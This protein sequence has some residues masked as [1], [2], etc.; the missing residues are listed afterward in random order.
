M[1][2]HRPRG[3]VRHVATTMSPMAAVAGKAA[4]Q[5]QAGMRVERLKAAAADRWRQRRAPTRPR[6][7]ALSLAPGAKFAW[8]QAAA[9]PLPQPG[10]A[11]VH[12]IAAATCDIDRALGLGAAPFPL[13][14]HF[15]HECVAEVVE[16]GDGVS[17]LRPGQRVI[18]PFQI[19][20]GRCPACEQGRTG[21][22]ESLPPISMY[23]FGL[24]GGHWGGTVS[25][26]LAVPF[27]EAM[28]VPVPDGVETAAVA[29]AA[30]NLADAHGRLAHHLP[31]LVEQGRGEVLI[32][33]SLSP[34]TDFSASVPLYVGQVALALGATRVRFADS[35]PFL[36][37][38]AERL[39]IEAL[40]SQ[41]LDSRELSPLT[42][43]ASASP[44]GLHVAIAMT[45][46]DGLVNSIGSL[47]T[48]AK[49]PTGLMFARNV[50]VHVGRSHAR[51]EIPAVLELVA[52]GKVR[53]AEV[54]TNLADLDDAP[55]ALREHVLG[56][57]TKTVLLES[58]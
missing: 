14:L 45:A 6:M 35:R 54:T 9:P 29:S 53:P 41:D 1:S 21:N 24:G 39:G 23:G 28:L 26:L 44:A 10:G 48:R 11:L 43:D 31:Q 5:R 33:G 58:P 19:N 40:R 36:R 49:I 37:A 57:A 25:E 22:C 30:D 12:P 20:C 13:P 38:H 50:T 15:G 8:K 2:A 16:V 46:E 47:H 55:R 56:E 27:A 17:G 7:R 52:A 3:W 34:R 32:V 42:V 18:V 51:A 4:M